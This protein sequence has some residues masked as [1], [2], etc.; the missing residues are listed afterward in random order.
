VLLEM[1]S[2]SGSTSSVASAPTITC[3]E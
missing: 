2:T 1:D 3:N